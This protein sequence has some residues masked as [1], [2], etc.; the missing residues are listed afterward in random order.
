MEPGRGWGMPASYLR[1]SNAAVLDAICTTACLGPTRTYRWCSQTPQLHVA[2]R[3]VDEEVPNILLVN[4][5]ARRGSHCRHSAASD[6]TCGSPSSSAR[7]SRAR[8]SFGAM[9]A[10]RC[11]GAAA[12]SG[13]PPHGW[14]R[15]AVWSRSY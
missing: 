11:L 5:L 13:E 8:A 1:L 4:D 15:L 9:A 10:T 3:R 7:I 6:R 2:V 14:W 12:G